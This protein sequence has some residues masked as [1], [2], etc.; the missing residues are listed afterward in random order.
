MVR[1]TK[2]IDK[3]LILLLIVLCLGGLSG[4]IPFI[5]KPDGSAL[6][7]T[8]DLLVHS[9]VSNYFWPGIFLLLSMS[10]WPIINIWGV[11]C[12]KSWASTS[13]RLLGIMTMGWI[14]YE[15]ATI[16]TFSLL[17][18]TIFILGLVILIGGVRRNSI[19][20]TQ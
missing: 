18:P 6:G 5:L 8:T 1:K 20:A 7:M 2:S 12:G 15:T 3:V 19:D 16:R 4:G 11:A 17:Q 13:I 10:L 14:I 9:P